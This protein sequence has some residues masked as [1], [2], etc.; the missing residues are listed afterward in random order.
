MK[1]NILLLLSLV[2]LI[3]LS[4]RSCVQGAEKSLTVSPLSITFHPLI[5]KV[6]KEK[7]ANKVNNS[8]TTLHPGIHLVYKS[9]RTITGAYLFK[10]SFGNVGGG[11]L[12]GINYTFLNYFSIGAAAGAYVRER[13]PENI[14]DFPVS[15][16]TEKIEVTPLGGVTV[17]AEVP[18]NNVH[19]IE[20]NC[21]LTVMANNCS[22]GL[23][24]KW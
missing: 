6:A 14:K 24:F 3:P 9:G 23:K 19:G 15:I 13:T 21:L 12:H 18:I 20:A 17:G 4:T 22:I 8:S 10:D 2:I 5:D 11:V 7:L 1:I 16:K